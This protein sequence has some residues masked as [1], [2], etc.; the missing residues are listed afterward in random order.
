MRKANLL[1]RKVGYWG[2]TTTDGPFLRDRLCDQSV[3]QQRTK[4][5][6]SKLESM[7]SMDQTPPNKGYPGDHHKWK[8]RPPQE[9]VVLGL[10]KKKEPKANFLFLEKKVGKIRRFGEILAGI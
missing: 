2:R 8:V 4:S 3:S 6:Q 7:P 1:K 10:T 9:E 5:A